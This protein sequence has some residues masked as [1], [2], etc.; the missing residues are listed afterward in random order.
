MCLGFFQCSHEINDFHMLLPS[1]PNR[2]LDLA[3]ALKSPP[4]IGTQPSLTYQKMDP[5]DIYDIK[6]SE[7]HDYRE[8]E[9][10]RMVRER[11]FREQCQCE[12]TSYI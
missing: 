5:Y 12:T 4:N 1:P 6:R 2:S 8:G 3:E 10:V 7:E 9:E 11:P